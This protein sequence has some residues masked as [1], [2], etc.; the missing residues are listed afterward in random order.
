MATSD[1]RVHELGFLRTKYFLAQWT[2]SAQQ[3]HRKSCFT[4]EKEI[5]QTKKKKQ[6]NRK[7]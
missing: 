2:F 1:V 6:P 4:L 5:I 7:F 3:K